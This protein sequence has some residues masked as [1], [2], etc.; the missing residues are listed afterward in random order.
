MPAMTA[1]RLRQAGLEAL[2]REL[3]VGGMVRFIQQFEMGSGDYTT[4]RWQ[5]LPANAE[6]ESLADAVEQAT[7]RQS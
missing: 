6:V 7:N 4:Q 5:W 1:E 2:R 3:G